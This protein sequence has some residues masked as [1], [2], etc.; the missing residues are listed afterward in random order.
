M[1]KQEFN[2]SEKR[3]WL[4]CSQQQAN[5]SMKFRKKISYRNQPRYLEKDIKEFIKRLKEATA[6]GN[7]YIDLNGSIFFKEKV[8][9]KLAGD[10]LK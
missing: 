5:R 2:L 8:I 4:E 7:N 9:D 1:V 10:Q 3:F 6:D